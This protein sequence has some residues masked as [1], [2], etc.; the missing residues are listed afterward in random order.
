MGKKVTSGD[1]PISPDHERALGSSA[2]KYQKAVKR[3]APE[4]HCDDSTGAI[5][6]GVTGGCPGFGEKSSESKLTRPM[7]NPLTDQ[8]E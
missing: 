2:L 8:F 3:N 1:T 7:Y 4:T 5:Q 6:G